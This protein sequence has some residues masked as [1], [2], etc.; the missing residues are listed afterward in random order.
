MG[1]RRSLML[2]TSYI[3]RII[4]PISRNFRY[5]LLAIIAVTICFIIVISI[6]VKNT[7]SNSKTK[8]NN[9]INDNT[10]LRE[11]HE[12]ISPEARLRYSFLD[13]DDLDVDINYLNE[14]YHPAQ[15]LNNNLPSTAS[16]QYSRI[17]DVK[18]NPN[19]IIYNQLPQ[20]YESTMGLLLQHI[21]YFHSYTYVSSQ[22]YVPYSYDKSSL[23]L[24]AQSLNKHKFK[25]LIYERH[26]YFFDHYAL[27]FSNHPVWINLIRDPIYRIAAEYEHSRE[28]CRTTDRCFVQE[29]AIS[30]T[31]DECVI[32]RSPK[33]CI[34]SQ[35]GVSRMLP[36]FCGLKYPI[37]CQEENDW[38]LKQ[39]KQN[40]DFFYTVVGIAE[41]FYKFLYVLEKLLPKYFKL[42]RL[43]FMNQRDPKHLIDERDLNIQLPNKNTTKLLMPFLKYEYDLYNYIKQRFLDQYRILV[44]LD[45]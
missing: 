30:E 14:D 24:I 4:L 27:Q 20:C 43:V 7:S 36:F 44:E 19:V 39:A 33:E 41:E 31:L 34:S 15:Q 40:I 13:I 6:T 35:N 17:L 11:S 23:I 32:K 3:Y 12:K 18:G 10:A 21:S 42:I 26:I 22:I 29:D 16:H 38:A 2:L 45:N 5:W 1:L 28:I 9:E 8:E 37:R 25:Q